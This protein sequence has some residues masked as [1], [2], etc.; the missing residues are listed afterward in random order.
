[1]S[2]KGMCKMACQIVVSMYAATYTNRL[3][4]DLFDRVIGT[5]KGKKESSK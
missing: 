1:M 3:V 4:G 5:S 2:F